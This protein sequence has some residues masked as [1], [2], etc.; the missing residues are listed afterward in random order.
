MEFVDEPN[1]DDE[2]INVE[3]IKTY[4]DPKATLFLLEQQW[5]T[6]KVCLNQVS[7]L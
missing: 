1:K 5:I 2:I 3:D 4:V 7:N 6:K